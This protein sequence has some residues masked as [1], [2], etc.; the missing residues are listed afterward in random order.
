MRFKN[1]SYAFFILALF[2][3]L[4]S[5][6]AV[7]QES[8]EEAYVP[9]RIILWDKIGQ[10]ETLKKCEEYLIIYGNVE[11][12]LTYIRYIES[13]NPEEYI[14]QLSTFS[15]Q[16]RPKPIDVTQS[17]KIPMDGS[18]PISM[19]KKNKEALKTLVFTKV[20]QREKV[21]NGD[22]VNIEYKDVNTNKTYIAYEST[23]E[24]YWL[25]LSSL[26]EQ[27]VINFSK[28][29]QSYIVASPATTTVRVDDQVRYE[30]IIWTPRA[31][32]S[33][34]VR[35]GTVE[36]GCKSDALEAIQKVRT[37]EYQQNVPVEVKNVRG[38]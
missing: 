10:R 25:E 11:P 12:E 27:K 9:D 34:E 35:L 20:G 29:C 23:E 24:G 18:T 16:A 37:R 28:R 38:K 14:L 5:F 1:F 22:M 7:S 4:S 32:N 2:S 3:L 30:Q 26:M 33:W 31:D 17:I 13:K 15:S 6:E 36:Q 21:L 8:D 19:K